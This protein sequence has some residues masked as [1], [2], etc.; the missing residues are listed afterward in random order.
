[1]VAPLI[2]KSSTIAAGWEQ[3]I[4]ELCTHG[5]DIP[6]DYDKSDDLPSLDAP[7]VLHLPTPLQEPMLHRWSHC[8]REFLRT[9]I[10]EVVHGVSD[11]KTVPFS[12]AKKTGRLYYTYHSRMVN[13]PTMFG[14]IDQLSYVVKELNRNPFSRRA[15]MVLWDAKHDTKAGDPPCL[16]R[17]WFR[18]AP[19][20]N[21]ADKETLRLDLH[22]SMR[23]NDA[24][25]AAF[26]NIVA[27]VFLQKHVADRLTAKLNKRV[28]VGAY[29]H[30]V[31]SYHI[32]GKDRPS[33]RNGFFPFIDRMS[34]ERRFQ[35]FNTA[36]T[37]ER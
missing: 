21:P 17:L 37:R 18:C 23:S 27:F 9:Y 5:I 22:V 10:D 3:S 36:M 26:A 19:P 29:T 1:M 16:Q 20:P 7:L 25:K 8:S 33:L 31:D 34:P 35:N 4:I 32:Y 2:V 12:V 28:L 14:A 6:T 15:Q 30:M 11:H 13:Y 24:Y